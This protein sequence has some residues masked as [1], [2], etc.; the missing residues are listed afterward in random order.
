MNKSNTHLQNLNNPELSVHHHHVLIVRQSVCI[1]PMD[2]YWLG[3]IGHHGTS[4]QNHLRH[5]LT[6]TVDSAQDVIT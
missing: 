1:F 6:H 2:R 3:G 4:A 5:H